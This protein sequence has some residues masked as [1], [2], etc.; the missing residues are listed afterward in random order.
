VRLLSGF[1]DRTATCRIQHT[2]NSTCRYSNANMVSATRL[3]ILLFLA[4][5]TALSI[6]T[7]PKNF[8]RPFPSEV[9]LLIY[10]VVAVTSP[11]ELVIPSDGSWHTTTDLSIR[12]DMPSDQLT[13]LPKA[14]VVTGPDTDGRQYTLTNQLGRDTP[15]M[16]IRGHQETCVLIKR[17]TAPH[18]V[19]R[20]ELLFIADD[21]ADV[22]I[23]GVVLASYSTKSSN[24]G[25]RGAGMLVDLTPYILAGETNVIMARLQ[26][27]SGNTGF[28]CDM[29]INCANIVLETHCESLPT[30]SQEILEVVTELIRKCD[31]P[32]FQIREA[33]MKELRGYA[34]QYGSQLQKVFS[35]A[36]LFGTLEQSWRV[37]TAW[38][39]KSKPRRMKVQTGGDCRYNF[40]FGSIEYFSFDRF[41]ELP[42]QI[43]YNHLIH[44]QT[45]RDSDS[46][47]FDLKFRKYYPSRDAAQMTAVVNTIAFLDWDHFGDL[48][49]Q[50][51]HLHPDTECSAAVA[52]AYARLTNLDIS[53][54]RYKWLLEAARS[55]HKP[56]SIAAHAA[57]AA[58]IGK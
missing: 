44:N 42:N 16:W 43:S 36:F 22:T 34:H 46:A 48:L 27:E 5:C 50:V 54:S 9:P 56:T 55:R 58:K 19:R 37:Q 57:L 15:A 32:S 1:V 10:P 28:A 31:D 4:V 29:R 12:W 49:D 13:L 26:N 25:N 35:S 52:S 47:K 17:F 8:S 53:E 45:V 30:V 14:M 2:P 38:I 24:W 21:A 18:S 40:A 20:A 23:N 11:D 51:S 3:L 41:P 7:D 39:A 6:A 33:S